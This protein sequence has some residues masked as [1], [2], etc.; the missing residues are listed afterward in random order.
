M[1]R[2][3]LDLPNHKHEQCRTSPAGFL[4]AFI[5]FVLRR[6]GLEPSSTEGDVRF[7]EKWSSREVN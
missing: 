1:E 6:L 3:V 7:H 5:F 2:K 4:G